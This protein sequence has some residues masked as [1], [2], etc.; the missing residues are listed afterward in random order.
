MKIQDT[1][2]VIIKGTFTAKTVVNTI[3]I[4]YKTLK[5][6]HLTSV[7]GAFV[8]S[9]SFVVDEVKNSH[10]FMI[11]VRL[12]NHERKG[13]LY[14]ETIEDPGKKDNKDA[15]ASYVNTLAIMTG[16]TMVSETD[17]K[18]PSGALSRDINVAGE[19]GAKSSIKTFVQDVQKSGVR[20]DIAPEA[21]K[22]LREYS[23]IN[24]D[25]SLIV[26]A[27]DGDDRPYNAEKVKKGKL[28]TAKKST[29]RFARYT[30]PSMDKSDEAVLN[31]VQEVVNGTNEYGKPNLSGWGDR[32]D[33]IPT[34]DTDSTYLKWGKRPGAVEYV[35]KGHIGPDGKIN[36]YAIHVF[37]KEPKGFWN[38]NLGKTTIKESLMDIPPELTRLRITDADYNWITPTVQKIKNNEA[39]VLQLLVAYYVTLVSGGVNEQQARNLMQQMFGK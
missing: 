13:K 30:R 12:S 7:Y 20:I 1:I 33:R 17:T 39:L 35:V 14:T 2:N 31:I 11:G 19:E 18:S 28:T 32:K 4:L 16:N 27:P 22:N 8:Y 29:E 15:F 24:N 10:F 9:V 21:I 5:D 37:G 6:K 38:N 23:W 36:P 3:P 26:V 25:T 34:S